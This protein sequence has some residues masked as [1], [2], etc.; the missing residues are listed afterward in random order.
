MAGADLHPIGTHPLSPGGKY[1]VFVHGFGGHWRDTWANPSDARNPWP[2]WLAEDLPTVRVW[3]L[4]YPASW[5]L[6]GGPEVPILDRA[7][8]L[9]EV[10]KSRGIGEHPVVFVCHS[11]GGL[12]VKSLLRH[13]LDSS[14]TAN[15]AIGGAT[16][17]LVLFGT[18][19]AGASLATFVVQALGSLGL[20]GALLRLSSLVA[21]MRAHRPELRDLN[22]WY[23]EA[24]QS[25]RLRSRTQVYYEKGRWRRLFKVVD[26]TSADP[27]IA[28]TD[29]IPLDGDHFSICKLADPNGWEYKSARRFVTECLAGRHQPRPNSHSAPPSDGRVGAALRAA[30]ERLSASRRAYHL[31]RVSAQP[32]LRLERHDKASE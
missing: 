13:S 5:T 2:E 30:R 3:S 27:G 23:R 6:W 28:G 14:D 26:E 4:E 20:L 32:Q 29:P 16:R 19:N 11:L 18:P 9:G 1:V 31:S 25:D 15:A 21:E 8:Q 22:R 10:L 12:I 17:G 7:A 24:V